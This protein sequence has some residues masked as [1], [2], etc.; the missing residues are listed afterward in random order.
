LELWL[1]LLSGATLT[2]AAWQKW[3]PGD[4]VETLGFVTGALCVYLV[5]KQHILNFPIGIANNLFFLFLFSR[6]RLYGDAGLQIVYVILAIH[7]WYLWLRGGR[8]RTR[9][10]VGQATA[11]QMLLTLGVVLLGTVGMTFLLRAVNGSAPVL[12]ALT[13]VLSLVAQYLLNRKLVQN[14]YLWMIADVI[15]IYL[16]VTRGLTLTAVLYFIFLCMCVAGLLS[17][18][19]SFNAVRGE[20][21]V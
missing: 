16:Y 20:A 19:R 2:V 14:W 11:R 13:T 15:Y 12:D 17:W 9:L 10:A 8:N 3:I 1:A 18:R 4:L 7:G 21:A 6:S 5:I